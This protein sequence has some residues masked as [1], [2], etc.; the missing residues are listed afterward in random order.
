MLN[1]SGRTVER[2]LDLSDCDSPVIHTEKI[3]TVTELQNSD[4]INGKNDID[5]SPAIFDSENISRKCI[6]ESKAMI[7]TENINVS[8]SHETCAVGVLL[9]L[10]EPMLKS[11]DSNVDSNS[12]ERESSAICD[13]DTNGVD[14]TYGQN[15]CETGEIRTEENKLSPK[16]CLSPQLSRTSCDD[17]DQSKENHNPLFGKKCSQGSLSICS[18]IIKFMRN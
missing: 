3:H 18:K 13:K 6:E 9:D 4:A 8:L 2:L 16:V 7:G 10:S 1:F 11:C 14:R 5:T 12:S 17:Q 15:G